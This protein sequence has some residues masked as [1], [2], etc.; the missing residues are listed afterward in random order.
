MKVGFIDKYLDEWHA[1]NM[2]TWLKDETQ[3]EVSV[4]YA[5]AM[6]DSLNEGGLT[7]RAWADKE[8]VILLDNIDELVQKSDAVVVLAPS[9]PELHERLS[10]SAL[11]SGKCTYI[12]K[13]F[14]PDVQSAKRMIDKALIN[15]TPMFSASALRFSK[16]LKNIDK[17][18]IK[19][20]S[21]RGPGPLGMYCIHQIE[22]IISLMGT[23]PEAVMFMG[24]E[25]N[26]GYVIR[27][28]DNRWA[29]AQH[30]DWNCPFNISIKYSDDKPSVY[31]NECTDYFPRFVKELVSFFKTR[32]LPV[33]YEETIAVIAVR[34]AILRS[35]NNPGKWT[36][37]NI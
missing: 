2:P 16:E 25:E 31:I 22:P 8:G 19:T 24:D 36:D 3:G 17:S 14:A 4:K 35:K 9:Y 30:F 12:D 10:D 27:F 29:A 21:M 32:K 28:K 1:N 13:S 6:M 33:S 5:Y 15:N 18:N 20:L 37:I 7:S 11:K 34:E 23:E 26:P